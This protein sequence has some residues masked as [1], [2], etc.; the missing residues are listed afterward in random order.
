MQIKL[1]VWSSAKVQNE[2]TCV[3][4]ENHEVLLCWVAQSSE[5]LP[6]YNALQVPLLL[7]MSCTEYMQT[8][9]V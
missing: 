3:Q 2:Y 5:I 8:Y 7:K 1:T 9:K 6:F 4:E